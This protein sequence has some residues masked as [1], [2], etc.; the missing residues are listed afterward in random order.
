MG[1]EPRRWAC[2]ML[3]PGAY[4]A[5]AAG[6]VGARGVVATEKTGAWA[7]SWRRSCP[8]CVR[9]SSWW[10]TWFDLVRKTMGASRWVAQSARVALSHDAL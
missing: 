4:W 1:W 8:G 10:L 5:Q 3:V 9:V 6:A 7:R 2:G